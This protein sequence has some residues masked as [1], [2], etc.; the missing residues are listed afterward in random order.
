MIGLAIHHQP[1]VSNIFEGDVEHYR[2]TGSSAANQRYAVWAI[3]LAD[4]QPDC[5]SH[6]ITW[7]GHGCHAFM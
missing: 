6:G 5:L 2:V 7:Q 4:M 1:D 3:H